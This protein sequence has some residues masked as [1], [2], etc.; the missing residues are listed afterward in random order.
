MEIEFI[1]S[2]YMEYTIG[3]IAYSPRK[4]HRSCLYYPKYYEF[5]W[6]DPPYVSDVYSKSFC[7]S[8]V[9]YFPMIVRGSVLYN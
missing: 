3:V 9:E 8:Y 6:E 4:R 7:V 5:M 1:V 2:T